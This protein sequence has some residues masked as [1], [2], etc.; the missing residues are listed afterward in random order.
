MP[1]SKS[2]CSFSPDMNNMPVRNKRCLGMECSLHAPIENICIFSPD[3]N[4]MP[5]RGKGCPGT[6]GS[7][8]AFESA[9]NI[10]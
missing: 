6:E 9:C 7:R 3:M 5:V 1:Q 8:R 4:N 10:S 2:I